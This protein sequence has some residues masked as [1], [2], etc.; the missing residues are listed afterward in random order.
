MITLSHKVKISDPCYSP[1][2]WCSA[3]LENVNAGNY[4]PFVKYLSTSWGVRVAELVVIKENL[5][6]IELDSPE[7]EHLSDVEIGVDSGQAGIF[8]YDYYEKQKELDEKFKEENGCDIYSNKWFYG[9]CC[10]VNKEPYNWG[11]I[12]NKGVNAQAGFG[13]GSYDLYVIKRKDLICAIKIV[14]INET[15]YNGDSDHDD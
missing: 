7:W 10:I 12:D 15:E 6:D 3:T 5:E 11:E 1:N 4:Y 2:T 9:K 14:F 8:D 13:D